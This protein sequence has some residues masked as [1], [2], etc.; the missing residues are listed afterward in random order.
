MVITH[1]GNQ[2]FKLQFGDITIAVNPISKDSKLKTARFGADVAL[3]SIN[4][5]DFNGAD[6]IGV[7]EKQPF[8]ITGPGE[9][10]TKGVFIKGFQSK[11]KYGG[12]THYNTIYTLTLDNIN[13][14]FLGAIDDI[15]DVGSEAM[16]AI[17]EVDMLFVP[18][19]GNGVLDP[20]DSYKLAVKLEPRMIIPVGL[21]TEGAQKD[22]LKVFC[23]EGGAPEPKPVDKL[24]LKKKDLDG[25][26]GEVTVFSVS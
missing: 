14:C 25:K 4:H 20:H 16:E 5:P 11:S 6:Q 8:V 23:K 13:M 3:I 22:A 9:Y 2:F 26:E 7:G 1:H 17:G 15:A 19:G 21:D 24:T 12:K 18:I 10:E